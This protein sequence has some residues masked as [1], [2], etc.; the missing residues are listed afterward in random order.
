[1]EILD[2]QLSQYDDLYETIKGN[3]GP[4][5]NHQ[6]LNLDKKL[7]NVLQNMLDYSFFKRPKDSK[8]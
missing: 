4:N 2:F 7:K 6:S 1:M 5:N 3:L 8:E